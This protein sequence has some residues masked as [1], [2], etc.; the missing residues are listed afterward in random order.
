MRTLTPNHH[1]QSSHMTPKGQRDGLAQSANATQ[2]YFVKK[3][4]T[5][6]GEQEWD[7]EWTKQWVVKGLHD[8]LES[9]TEAAC[10][11]LYRYGMGRNQPVTRTLPEGNA[12]SQF[13]PFHSTTDFFLNKL[14]PIERENFIRNFRDD[15]EGFVHLVVLSIFLEEN[16]LHDG[17]F[18]LD[19][20][21][22]KFMKIDHGQSF[23]SMRTCRPLFEEGTPL[24]KTLKGNAVRVAPVKFWSKESAEAFYT[25]SMQGLADLTETTDREQK[26]DTGGKAYRMTPE[27]MDG[28]FSNYFA[29]RYNMDFACRLGYTASATPLFDQRLA[30]FG[31]LNESDLPQLEK[32]KY[33]AIAKI[34]FTSDEFY[35]HLLRNSAE[36]PP[37][38]KLL[39]E[40]KAK[41]SSR[42]QEL[43]QAVT[44]DQKFM[45]F[46]DENCGDVKSKIH[47]SM[48]RMQ[49][50]KSGTIGRR[51][52]GFPTGAFPFDHAAYQQLTPHAALPRTPTASH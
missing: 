48:E 41:I 18:G 21:T 47:E 33:A 4:R 6:F 14:T 20:E 52:G 22:G 10:G 29:G 45:A 37:D 11:E 23:N 44:G 36:F 43:L 8:V 51:Y 40:M 46:L 30:T 42:K 17:N 26:L 49:H 13:V 12:A 15:L 31:L 3:E 1:L 9:C 5:G 38:G 16:D 32:F 24:K 35:V 7:K 19:K 28:L 27:F 25:K 34:L 39:E 2:I 50:N